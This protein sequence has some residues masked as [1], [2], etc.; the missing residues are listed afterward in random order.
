MRK[1]AEAMKSKHSFDCRNF[2]NESNILNLSGHIWRQNFENEIDFKLLIDKF[3]LSVMVQ[4]SI[5]YRI[6][7][8]ESHWEGLVR[9]SFSCV[10]QKLT[11]LFVSIM[12]KLKF[13]MENE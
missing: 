1:A 8:K 12:S 5:E 6:Y 13:R 4:I 10:I 9:F 11:D 3:S 7:Q 2:W